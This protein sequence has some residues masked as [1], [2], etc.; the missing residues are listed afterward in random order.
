M[1][2]RTPGEKRRPIILEDLSASARPFEAVRIQGR[3]RDG[4]GSVL[5]VQ[6]SEGGKWLDFSLSTKIDQSGQFTTQ[7]EFGRPG[8]YRLRVI[9]PDSGVTFKPFVVVIKD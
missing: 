6:R 3:Y 7:A 1:N 8:R 2:R 9:D 4:A 5:R